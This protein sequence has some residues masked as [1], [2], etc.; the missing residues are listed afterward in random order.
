VTSF[1]PLSAH[2]A[3]WEGMD[4]DGKS[5]TVG[6]L[7]KGVISSKT[8]RSQ[9]LIAAAKA[10]EKHTPKE[11]AAAFKQKM[12]VRNQEY[13]A[14]AVKIRNNAFALL[15]VK[16][17]IGVLIA[18]TR[19]EVE[20]LE[21]PSLIDSEEDEFVSVKLSDKKKK[22]ASRVLKESTKEMD[23]LLEAL[24]PLQKE[25]NELVKEAKAMSEKY[26][27]DEEVAV[28][29]QHTFKI[30]G[31]ME[32]K[33]Q[34]ESSKDG[35]TTIS[36]SVFLQAVSTGTTANASAGSPLAT[37]PLAPPYFGNSRLTSFAGLYDLYEWLECIIEWRPIVSANTGGT[38]V[39]Y[40]QPDIMVDQSVFQL[41]SA[42]VRDALS[43][44]GSDL[45]SLFMYAAYVISMPQQAVYYTANNEVPNLAIAGTFNMDTGNA[46]IPG[47]TALGILF[48]HYKIRFFQPSAARVGTNNINTISTAQV[49]AFN[50]VVLTV[51]Q[52]FFDVAAAL[53]SIVTTRQQI[54]SLVVESF[55]DS[56]TPVSWRTL[57]YGDGA[58]T[59]VIGVGTRLWCRMDTTGTS[60]I[61]Y[62]SFGAAVIGTV[63]VAG[64]FNDGFYNTATNTTNAGASITFNN[65]SVFTLMEEL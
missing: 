34:T 12:M 30:S 53:N 51:N 18:G 62:P 17:K 37:W 11:L 26:S 35:E 27:G 60:V 7:V 1:K 2:A 10:S 14:L 3:H 55:S 24:V 44:N 9:E 15:D 58:S 29:T 4:Y 43:H 13:S 21:E 40:C 23:K 46:A 47:A 59:M 65:I 5:P 25:K 6:K 8:V 56:T 20:E 48:M 61:F 52:A 36:G 33:E 42:E 19:A 38:V 41:G 63:G 28:P 49:V 39:G 22:R 64:S 45:N 32:E 16:K 50:A 54:A 57:R 31:E